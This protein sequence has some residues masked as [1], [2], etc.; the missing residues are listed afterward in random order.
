MV[1][2]REGAAR[3]GD[4][5]YFADV[6]AGALATPLAVAQ[7][8]AALAAYGDQTRADRL[9]AQAGKMIGS[10]PTS[11]TQVWR[12]DY[13]T[14]LRDRAA[15]L[16]LA[17]EAGSNAIDRGLLSGALVTEGPHMSPQ[18]QVWTLMAAQ[19][20]IDDPSTAGLTLNGAEV[21]GPLVRMVEADTL[22][23]QA[24][25]NASTAD[26]DITLT[27]IGVPEVP[28]NAGGYGYAIER[29]YYDIDGNPV[30]LDGVQTGSRLVAV[31][32]VS[33]FEKGE[34][35]LMVND[36]L[37]AGLEIDNPN[38]LR[39]GDIRAL[40]WLNPIEARHT[41]FRADRFLAAVDWRSDKAFQLA[42]IVRA[43]SPGQYHH[44][45]ATVEDMYRPRYR[46][47]TN[48]GEMAVS[49]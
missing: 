13:G 41:E 29:Q 6:K 43:V 48:T 42:Y 24:I 30:S 40:D 34:A 49:E 21:S 22:T 15:V 33:P 3:M 27:T 11:E 10:Q 46:A 32:K 17:V 4:L 5:R 26:T 45:A 1:L 35:R 9:F 25:R 7:L 37:P 44:P 20:L 36:P 28:V 8:G 23:P 38:L 19:A 14:H 39:S 47:R 31:L 16:T 18:E 12:A 2:A